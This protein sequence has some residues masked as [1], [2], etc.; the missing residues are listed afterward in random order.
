MSFYSCIFIF[1]LFTGCVG[2]QYVSSPLYIPVNEKKGELKSNISYTGLQVGYSI[3]NNF[4]IF[5][6]YDFMVR[7]YRS[8]WPGLSS[9][10][11]GHIS[12]RYGSNDYNFGVSIF[13]THNN[14]FTEILLAGGIGDMFYN[15]FMATYLYNSFYLTVNKKNLYIQPVLGYKYSDAKHKIEFGLF[16][17]FSYTRYTD[18]NVTIFKPDNAEVYLDNV[19]FVGK[20]N[21]DLF[22]IEP[23]FFFRDG[24]EHIKYQFNITP[25]ISLN[26]KHVK[27]R[28]FNLF[29]GIFLNFDLLNK[30]LKK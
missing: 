2:Y 1:I 21:L 20:K 15:N 28:F 30:T 24:F 8:N 12:G 11:D 7:E 23:G 18:I 9:E 5:G 10:H 27:Y 6:D 19:Y 13:K 14:F 4:S 29:F 22:F 3:S 17:R 26:S 16:S 25:T